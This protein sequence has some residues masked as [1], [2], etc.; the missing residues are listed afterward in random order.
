MVKGRDRRF[1][2]WSRQPRGEAKEALQSIFRVNMRLRLKK[3]KNGEESES[4]A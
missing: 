3:R 2:M 1:F 4:H